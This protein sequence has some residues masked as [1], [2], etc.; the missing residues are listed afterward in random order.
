[1]MFITTLNP[2]Y[3]IWKFGYGIAWL[4]LPGK[5]NVGALSLPSKK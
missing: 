2:G 3:L 5:I 1:M 4:F